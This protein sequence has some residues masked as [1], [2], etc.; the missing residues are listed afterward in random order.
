M[1]I[2]G[3]SA[4]ST[5]PGAVPTLSQSQHI[6]LAAP[7]LPQQQSQSQHSIGLAPGP[8]SFETGKDKPGSG[9]SPGHPAH[10]VILLLI[11]FTLLCIS[12]LPLETKFLIVLAVGASRYGNN[13]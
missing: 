6:G 7:T 4:I 10:Q 5:A 2:S 3:V 1:Q 9:D 12:W 13:Q 11:P 8:S